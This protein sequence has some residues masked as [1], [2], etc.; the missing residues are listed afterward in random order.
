MGEQYKSIFVIE[1]KKEVYV[2]KAVTDIKIQDNV[3][4]FN[5]CITNDEVEVKLPQKTILAR[6]KVKTLVTINLDALGNCKIKI[7]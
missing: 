2:Y 5:H 4:T 7:V 1:G 3:L 6:K